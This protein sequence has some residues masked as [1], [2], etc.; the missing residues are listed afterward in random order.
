MIKENIM[1]VDPAKVKTLVNQIRNSDSR[2]LFEELLVM[3]SDDANIDD[4]GDHV[5]LEAMLDEAIF[6]AKDDDEAFA[7]VSEFMDVAVD[8]SYTQRY[9][10]NESTKR[11]RE[12]SDILEMVQAYLVDDDP[13]ILDSIIVQTIERACEQARSEYSYDMSDAE[14]DNIADYVEFTV[15]VGKKRQ[16]SA[17]VIASKITS[18]LSDEVTEDLQEAVKWTSRRRFDEVT[19]ASYA[20]DYLAQVDDP[21]AVD[22]DD[23]LAWLKDQGVSDQAISKVW[24]GTNKNRHIASLADKPKSKEPKSSLG[25]AIA[26]GGGNASYRQAAKAK[27]LDAPKGESPVQDKQPLNT[28]ASEPALN[29]A[30]QSKN[31]DQPSGKVYTL[32]DQKTVADIIRRAGYRLETMWGEDS[33]VTLRQS[34]AKDGTPISILDAYIETGDRGPRMDHGGESGDGWMG[35]AEIERNFSPYGK[36][37]APRA[38]ALEDTLKKEGYPNAQVSVD[39]G[40]KGH[41]SLVVWITSA[42]PE[43]KQEA[44]QASN[45]RRKTETISDKEVTVSIIVDMYDY[46]AQ[47]SYFKELD[48][49]DIEYDTQ[50]HSYDENN[51]D[52]EIE[53]GYIEIIA[54][55]RD[56]S[57]AQTLFNKAEAN[58]H[59]V[60]M[61]ES[62]KSIKESDDLDDDLDDDFS[63]EETL[64]RDDILV[65]VIKYI[66]QHYPDHAIDTDQIY[67]Y[68]NKVF[69]DDDNDSPYDDLAEMIIEEYD[70]DNVED[71]RTAVEKI[72]FTG[73]AADIVTE[74]YEN[75]GATGDEVNID[76]IYDLLDAATDRRE[77]AVV[78]RAIKQLPG[79]IDLRIPESTGAGFGPMGSPARGAAEPPV[80]RNSNGW[81]KHPDE[82]DYED[83][84]F[85]ED[86]P[87]EGWMP[88]SKKMRE[89]K[90]LID[91]IQE[92]LDI[93]N[94]DESVSQKE[95]DDFLKTE[96]WDVS[97][98]EVQT[99]I[100]DILGDKAILMTENLGLFNS[101]KES[102]GY[103]GKNYFSSVR[104]VK[105]DMKKGWFGPET[106]EEIC[107]KFGWDTDWIYPEEESDDDDDFDSFDE[108]RMSDLDLEIKE[109]R[110]TGAS[111]EEIAETLNIDLKLLK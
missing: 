32:A 1:A 56:M 38:K 66:D 52:E 31:P 15:T 102:G 81:E 72:G 10:L 26:K 98:V 95:L 69:N 48:A 42:S 70:Y 49:L 59:F 84:D 21:T 58:E 3:M 99:R 16:A 28:K 30:P 74:W 109:L 7:R 6:G 14:I 39:Y 82:P 44:S 5:E 94:S 108:S 92:Y 76:D 103:F 85:D 12:S 2:G 11:I 51:G 71:V 105:N 83:D 37:W 62:V 79:I 19:R 55:F 35:S 60:T 90:S 67:Y 78:K 53:D 47:S 34:K 43:R 4:I 13:L 46:Q 65:E 41:I 9:D 86:D 111:D 45:L 73:K 77:I 57:L 110:A 54:K 101:L 106:A 27:K 20:R 104:D 91:S 8:E 80:R 18:Y 25:K 93:N 33:A 68:F 100:S 75:E 63:H 96:G 107:E 50:L 61:D 23:Y 40:E 88:E 89:Q 22:Y 29:P 17:Q 24:F 36:K 87:F 97:D 64:S